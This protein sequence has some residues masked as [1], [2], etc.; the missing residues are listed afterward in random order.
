MLWATVRDAEPIGPGLPRLRYR[1]ALP[2]GR[3]TAMR[4]AVQRYAPAHLWLGE[5]KRD[6]GYMG[7]PDT[8]R[9]PAR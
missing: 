1:L 3:Q 2:T 5:V 7:R 4:A 9:R 6:S 8:S